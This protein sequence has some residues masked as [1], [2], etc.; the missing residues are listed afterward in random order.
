VGNRDNIRPDYAENFR[1]AVLHA[2]RGFGPFSVAVEEHPK[3]KDEETLDGMK[4]CGPC[5]GE[6]AIFHSVGLGPV[7]CPA[8]E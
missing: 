5:S 8:A 4:Y 7:P 3:T 2:R 6:F 1:Q